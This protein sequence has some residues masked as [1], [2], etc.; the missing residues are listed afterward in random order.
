MM[1]FKGKL[2]SECPS[3][4]TVLPYARLSD[5][6]DRRCE[7]KVWLYIHYY[8]WACNKPSLEKASKQ[9]LGLRPCFDQL[10]VH[11]H[12]SLLFPFYFPSA[13]FDILCSKWF[14]TFS[15]TE[16]LDVL[17]R[18]PYYLKIGSSKT[19][20]CSLTNDSHIRWY[21]DGKVA[22][23]SGRQI[24]ISGNTL[25]INDIRVSD[26]GTYECRGLKYTTFFTIYVIGR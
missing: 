19:L 8:L 17:D 7:N 26:G 14:N 1:P 22:S 2:L 16:N 3:N 11:Y 5:S 20:P 12:L 23:T 25:T 18:N 6:K 9:S 13:P 10:Q 21:I 4:I 24:K 15:S